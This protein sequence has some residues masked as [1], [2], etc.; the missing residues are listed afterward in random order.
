[1]LFVVLFRVRLH[2]YS[3]IHMHKLQRTNPM[4]LVC[5]YAR[6]R[7]VVRT[8]YD[9]RKERMCLLTR[10]IEEIIMQTSSLQT[11]F[12]CARPPVYLHHIR[13]DAI[14]N[15]TV[16]GDTHRAVELLAAVHSKT[17]T[18]SVLFTTYRRSHNL[19]QPLPRSRFAKKARLHY[20]YST[21]V[22]HNEE[23]ANIKRCLR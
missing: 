22:L 20:R 19:P 5:M 21:A 2:I 7:C 9:G 8:I 4:H 14:Y 12:V 6:L 23:S 16:H 15:S 10:G 13:A 3:T 1:M 18:M 17:K 11:F